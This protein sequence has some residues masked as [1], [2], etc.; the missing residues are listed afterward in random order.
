M[1]FYGE[2]LK[3]YRESKKLTQQ[4]LG[5]KVQRTRQS[6]DNY[7]RGENKPTPEIAYAIRRVL[8]CSIYDISDLNPE[9]DDP[10]LKN[11]FKKVGNHPVDDILYKEWE[12][13][14]TENKYKVLGFIETL[15]KDGASECD[16][17]EFRADRTA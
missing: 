16:P 12:I 15:K 6:I 10:A 13:L 11:D 1:L 8:G 14:S 2:K 17:G 3:K 9:P 5:D 7:E 4:E